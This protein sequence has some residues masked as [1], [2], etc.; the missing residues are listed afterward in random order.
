MESLRLIDGGPGRQISIWLTQE[1]PE[2]S[3]AKE[4]VR[5]E[6]KRDK[7]GLSHIHTN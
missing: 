7:T 3:Q 2:N 5:M 6:G 1:T 4:A